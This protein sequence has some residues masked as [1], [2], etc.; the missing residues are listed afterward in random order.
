MLS[1]TKLDSSSPEGLFLNLES[2][3][4]SKILGYTF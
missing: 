1:E 3:V 2:F 4:L